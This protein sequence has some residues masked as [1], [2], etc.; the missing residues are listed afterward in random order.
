ARGPAPPLVGPVGLM[1]P[2]IV[3]AT[4]CGPTDEEVTDDRSHGGR[5]VASR[6]VRSLLRFRNL[7]GR[8]GAYPPFSSWRLPH[9][10]GSTLSRAA[11]WPELIPM[12]PLRAGCV[13]PGRGHRSP[14]SLPE[15]PL[16][17]SPRRRRSRRPRGRLRIAHGADRDQ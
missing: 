2:W 6:S 4:T 12:S 10:T 9:V 7:L 17:P 13:H 5:R 16:E 3:P 1:L 11:R 14:Q 15:L 8:D